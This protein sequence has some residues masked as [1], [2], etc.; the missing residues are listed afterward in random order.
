MTGCAHFGKPRPKPQPPVAATP[1][2]AKTKSDAE[3]TSDAAGRFASVSGSPRITIDLSAQRA[4]FYKGDELV[5]TSRVSSGKSGFRTPTGSFRITQKERTHRSTTYGKYVSASGSVINGD[6]D[7]RK[8]P[9]PEGASYVGASMPYFMRFNGPV[10][11]HAGRV[12]GY[13]ASH[14]CVRLPR[15]MAMLFYEHAPV[16]TP[17]TVRE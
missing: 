3:R 2:P 4:Y 13:P 11:M 1:A 10:G 5:T 9:K 12:P 6:V 7:V 8:E 16:G 17:V 14:G 15:S